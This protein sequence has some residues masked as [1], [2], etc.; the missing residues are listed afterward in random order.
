VSLVAAPFVALAL[1]VPALAVPATAGVAGALGDDR[2]DVL[3]VTEVERAIGHPVTPTDPP[4]GVGGA[5]AFTVDGAPADAVNVWVLHGDDAEEGFEVGQQIGSDDA[6]E[7]PTLDDDA[8]YLGDPLNTAYV[9]RDGTLVHLQYYVFSGDDTPK[10]IKKAVVKMVK[11][12]IKR[13]TS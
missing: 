3:S 12:A 10:Q 7:L 5:C 11:R 13:A 2:C 9:L 1:S 8:F 6:V 4:K